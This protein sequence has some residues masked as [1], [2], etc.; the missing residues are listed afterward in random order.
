MRIKAVLASPGVVLLTLTLGACGQTTGTNT[1]PS[2]P[3]DPNAWPAGYSPDPLADR[4]T[5]EHL[6]DAAYTTMEVE[7]LGLVNDAR[8]RG[9][10]CT[11]PDGTTTVMPSVRALRMEGHLHLAARRHGTDMLT[12]GYFAHDAPTP[13]PNGV[14]LIDRL[15]NAGLP[16]P[17]AWGENL[18]SGQ[19]SARQA[20]DDWLASHDHCV[21]LMSPL[22]AYAGVGLVVRD[23]QFMWTN[24]FAAGPLTA[25]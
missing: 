20:V 6:G 4:L 18:A 7:A 23:G 22:H 8:A 3:A 13:A 9:V 16:Q 2:A 5:T 25:R 21:N 19:T 17:S 12:R 1:A 15:L 14:R 10:T 11:K 24:D